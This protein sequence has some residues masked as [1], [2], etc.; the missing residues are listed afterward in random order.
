MRI[1][2]VY[3]TIRTTEFIEKNCEEIPSNITADYKVP[4][5]E[6]QVPLPHKKQPKKQPQLKIDMN[7]PNSDVLGMP[8]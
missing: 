4:M 8:K 5:P 3:K 2:P 6:Y 1:Q 7:I